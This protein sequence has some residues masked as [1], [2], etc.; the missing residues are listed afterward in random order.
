MANRIITDSSPLIILLKSD[1]DYILPQLFEEIFVPEAV[2]EEI[3]SGRETDTAKQKLPFISW[4][5]RISVTTSNTKIENYNLG[6]GEAEVLNLAL[7]LPDSGVILDDFAARKCAKELKMLL[8]GTGGMLILAKRKGL[9]SSVSE[10]LK[11]VQDKGLWLSEDII[12]LLKRKAG[13]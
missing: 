8:L 3:L 12:K 2:W 1:L 10:A 11:K 7:V 5:K 13:E 9:I 6:K 4:A